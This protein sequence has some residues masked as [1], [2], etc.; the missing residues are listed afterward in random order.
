MGQTVPGFGASTLG[1]VGRSIYDVKN[2]N[3][4]GAGS[5][6]DAVSQGNQTIVFDMSGEIKP[7]KD[8]RVSGSFITSDGT[9]VPSGVTLKYGTLW[10]HGS[11]GAHDVIIR[12]IRSREE[13]VWDT[14]SNTDA[15]IGIGTSAYNVV[16]DRIA[17]RLRPQARRDTFCTRTGRPRRCL[18]AHSAQTGR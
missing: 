15:G 10:H 4:S 11:H 8:I 3:D 12:G 17:I 2:L 6:C 7:S 1:G 14:C 16:L 13:K 5:L 18:N 9:K